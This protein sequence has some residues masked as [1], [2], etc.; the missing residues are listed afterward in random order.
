MPLVFDRNAM[1]LHGIKLAAVKANV[2]EKR[3]TYSQVL[4]RVLAPAKLR[5][6]LRVDEADR[7]FVWVTTI[8]KS[9]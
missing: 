4:S 8:R 1:A 3:M 9:G 6:E 5:Y 2:P 7:P